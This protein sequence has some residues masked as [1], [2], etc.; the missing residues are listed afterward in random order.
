MEEMVKDYFG[1]EQ[2]DGKYGYMHNPQAKWDWWSLGGRWRGLLPVKDVTKAT[3]GL[4]GV[5]GERKTEANT[6]DATKFSNLDIE[7]ID[8]LME[9]QINNFW[10]EYQKWLEIKN[11]GAL[12]D[13]NNIEVRFA[14]HGD[15]EAMGLARI[16]KDS[17]PILDPDGSV[18]KDKNGR[19]RY[20]KAEWAYD[21]LTEDELRTKFKWRFGFGTYAVLD[22][23]GWKEK[24][25][26]GWFGTSSDT[27]E[28]RI[29]WGSNYVDKFLRNEDPDTIVA[30]VDCHI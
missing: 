2:K 11:A 26:M 3:Q 10:A 21:D 28:D 14:M 16:V 1:Y 30:V 18:A 12:E 24:G 25:K 23:E 20:T 15:L 8:R 4:P 6:A 9:E 27:I 5:F 19:D 7:R 13:E 22:D 29:E 17:A